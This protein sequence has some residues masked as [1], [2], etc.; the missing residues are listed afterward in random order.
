MPFAKKRSE[1]I[2]SSQ[3]TVKLQAIKSSRKEPSARV[4]RAEILLAYASHEAI[5]SIAKRFRVSRPTVERCV[6]KALTGGI[7]MALSELPRSG[8]PAK[9][10]TSDKAWVVQLACTQP[11]EFEYPHEVWTISLLARHVRAK[12][13]ESGHPSLVR[14]GKSHIHNILNESEIRP[15]KIRYYLEQRD[16]EFEEKMAQIL[17]VYKEVQLINEEELKGFN[18]RKWAAICYDEKPG[19]QAIGNTGPDRPPIPRNYSTISRNHGYKRHGTLSLLAGIDL[20]TGTIVSIVRDRHRS[21]EFI[22]FLKLSDK[23]Y[24]SDWKIRIILDNHKVHTSRETMAWLKKHPNRFEFIFTPKHGSWL[25]LIETFFSKMTRSFLRHI[26]VTSKK[27]L[28]ERIIHYLNDINKEP[29]VFR[30]KYK[31]NELI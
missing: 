21:A 22:D 6:D 2:L 24:P 27:E 15:H 19:I 31:M 25:N 28:K 30:W 10:T 7:D 13:K 12:A 14:A 9:I 18:S 1:L 23:S 29:V 4:R 8:R 3:D 20:H 16:P 26:R 11:K 17:L 5:N